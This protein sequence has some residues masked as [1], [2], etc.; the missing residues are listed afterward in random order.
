MIS[1]LNISRFRQK[2]LLDSRIQLFQ[3]KTLSRGI[4]RHAH[5]GRDLL[6]FW[7]AFETF[8]ELRGSPFGG[9]MLSKAEFTLHAFK[10]AGEAS[11]LLNPDLHGGGKTE[12]AGVGI[13]NP[14]RVK[15][16]HKDVRR[17]D[18]LTQ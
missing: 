3:A 2:L 9:L 16:C 18:C 4:V 5:Q 13:I 15:H 8:L 11:Y 6:K 7:R 10:V 1:R 14:L 12:F 17:D